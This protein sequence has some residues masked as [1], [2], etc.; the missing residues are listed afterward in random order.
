LVSTLVLEE[1]SGKTVK[2]EIVV[3]VVVVVIVVV[4]LIII[5]T[6]EAVTVPTVA[7]YII[8]IGI[9]LLIA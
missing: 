1:K 6:I 4:V 9:F 2:R 8:L 5:I 3:V 7:S